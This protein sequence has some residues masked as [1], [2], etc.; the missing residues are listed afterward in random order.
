MVADGRTPWCI[1]LESEAFS[2]WPGTDWVETLVL[3]LG[4]VDLYERW[5]AGEVG[6]QDPVVRQ[7]F[8]RFGDIAFGDSFILYGRDAMGRTSHFDAMDHLGTDPPGCWMNLNGDWMARNVRDAT[9]GE[10]G[11][12]VLPP[13]DV[14]GDAAVLGSPFQVGALRDRPEIR[15][16]VRWL[17]DP[18]WGANRAATVDA[19]LSPN[20]HFDPARC[21]SPDLSE[22]ANAVRVHLCEVQRDTL[23]AGIQRPDASDEMPSEIGAVTESDRRGAFLQGMLDYVAEGPQSLDRILAEIDAAWP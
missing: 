21:A 18:E 3:R 10:V 22:E 11:F 2:G 19:L 6:F 15:E 1:G 4:G 14:G 8:A 17:L 12:F 20:L 16:F 9:G 5:M 23:A 7:A 13:M